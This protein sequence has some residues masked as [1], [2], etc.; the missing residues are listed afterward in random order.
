MVRT[1][2]LEQALTWAR[3][4]YP[5]ESN[6]HQCACANSIVYLMTG[7]AGGYGGPSIR[8]HTVSLLAVSQRPAG[9][10]TFED[11][12][13]FAAPLCFGPLTDAHRRVAVSQYCHDDDP[14][15]LA[16]LGIGS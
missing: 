12:C 3:T 2:Y 10:W 14:A 11:A 8:E 6:E 9:L 13:A 4:H 1:Q 16:A 7:G 15:D 5:G